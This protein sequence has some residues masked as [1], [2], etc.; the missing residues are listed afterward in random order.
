MLKVIVNSVVIHSFHWHFFLVPTIYISYG[1]VPVGSYSSV[2]PAMNT[3]SVPSSEQDVTLLTNIEGK[4]N[5]PNNSNSTNSI[6]TIL[7]FSSQNNG[8]YKF[9]I[10]NWDGVELCALQIILL[11][12]MM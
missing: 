10:T 9:Y 11:T 7:S 8:V 1:L 5:L 4:W 12:G 2:Y 6:L 3:L